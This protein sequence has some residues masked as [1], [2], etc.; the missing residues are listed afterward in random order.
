MTCLNIQSLSS[1]ERVRIEAGLGE[2]RRAIE[3]REQSL[4]ILRE[5][6]DRRGEGATLGM[7]PAPSSARRARSSISSRRILAMA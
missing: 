6:G 1:S 5:I 4:E 2:T 3:F 7:V